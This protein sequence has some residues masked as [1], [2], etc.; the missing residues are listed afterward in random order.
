[1]DMCQSLEL[2]HMDYLQLEPSKGEFENIVKITQHFIDYVQAHVIQSQTIAMTENAFWQNF[3]VCYY[4]SEKITIDQGSNF[5]SEL[6]MT[7]VCWQNFRKDHSVSPSDKWP[8]WT[9]WFNTIE[10]WTPLN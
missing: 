3:A 5:E 6:I 4:F 10:Y 8:V 1:M 9:V 7:Y 2:I